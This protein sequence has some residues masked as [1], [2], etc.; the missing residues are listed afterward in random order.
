MNANTITYNA[1]K[2]GYNEVYINLKNPFGYQHIDT[3]NFYNYAN[4]KPVAI[5]EVSNKIVY[6]DTIP[7]NQIKLDGSES[8]DRDAIYGGKIDRYNF[9]ILGGPRPIT[10]SYIDQSYS[11]QCMSDNGTY[12]CILYTIDNDGEKSNYDTVI[13]QMN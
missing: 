12:T 6:T 11:T 2:S 13:Y 8:Y 1:L 9:L 5:L 3:I 7:C 4:L 10:S